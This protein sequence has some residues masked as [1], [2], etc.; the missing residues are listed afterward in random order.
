M[1]KILERS[2]ERI[3]GFQLS[4]KVTALLCKFSASSK[5]DG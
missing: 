1:I 5:M 2:T 4:G 3:I